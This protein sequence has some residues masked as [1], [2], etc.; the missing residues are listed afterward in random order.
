MSDINVIRK[1]AE[2]GDA[3]SQ[4]NLGVAYFNG[5]VVARDYAQA[6]FWHSKAAEQGH[7]PALSNLGLYHARGWGVAKDV[8]QAIT[9]YR[10]AIDLGE[11]WAINNLGVL[12][13]EGEGVAKDE[14]EAYAHYNLAG[15]TLE[16]ARSNRK[17]LE[18][19]LS[20]EEIA[21]GQ[22]RTKELQKEIAARIAAKAAGN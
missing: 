4:Y 2:K 22:R 18:K 10:I 9:Y 17:K 7:A 1:K 8:V 20:R 15:I 5:E 3:Q 16:E 12:Y 13:D 19:T 14:V 6:F 11:P 21:A